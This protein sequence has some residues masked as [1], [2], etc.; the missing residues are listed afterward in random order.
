MQCLA[1]QEVQV[2]G[3]CPPYRPPRSDRDCPLDTA[4]D[5]CLWHASGT[6]GEDDDARTWR[7]RFQLA[8]GRAPFSVTTA[9]LARAIG[10]RQHW[11]VTPHGRLLRTPLLR[12]APR[13]ESRS[14]FVVGPDQRRLRILIDEDATVVG[15]LGF[16][17]Q[18]CKRPGVHV[19]SEAADASDRLEF[20][21]VESDDDQ[22]PFTITTATGGTG[23]AIWPYRQWVERA[24]VLDP[25]STAA[26]DLPHGLRLA[27]AAEEIQ[28]DALVTADPLL[29]EHR[30]DSMLSKANVRS[31]QEAI[32]LVGLFLRSRGD[33]TVWPEYPLTYGRGL[34]YWGLSRELLPSAWR[35]FSACVASSFNGGP[36]QMRAL[37]EA[38]IRRVDRALRCR[39]LVHIELAKP[40]SRDTAGE[41]LFY[42]D[43]LLVALGG[44][45]DAVARVA[46]ITYAM[47]GQLRWASWRNPTWLKRLS[48]ADTNLA[49]CMASATDGA[50]SLE[51]VATLRN[52]LH[53]EALELMTL[54]RGYGD[55][56]SLVTVPD[57]EAAKVRSIVQRHPA[58]D[59]FGFENISSGMALKAEVLC[60]ALVPWAVST[61]DGLMAATD[62]T[63]L[64]GVAA[65]ALRPG[66]PTDERQ[67]FPGLFE[68]ETRRRL[69]MLAGL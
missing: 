8:G 40:D 19:M 26:G 47:S 35:W 13:G 46:H 16:L 50:D 69:R 15:E 12:R 6:A 43:S 21:P 2:R 24:R 62:I 38:A 25:H 23:M 63:R 44:A 54:S 32:A 51:L 36:S 60:E 33:Y 42:L 31:V 45:F 10:P 5:R 1:S 4:V 56:R 17:R 59:S 66:P 30:S 55:R 22:L 64:P 3:G 52:C 58:A 65:A 67:G 41:S 53:G 28:V 27:A 68:M 61:L 11:S 34:Y 57:A 37:G 49:S 39:D 48:H 7:R 29:L 20:Q 9:S 18:V 14:A